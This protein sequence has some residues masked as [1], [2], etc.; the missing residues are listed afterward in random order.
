MGIV[1]KHQQD[2]A[3]FTSVKAMLPWIEETIKD[4]GGMASCG[5]VFKDLPKPGNEHYW[6]KVDY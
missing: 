2:Y 3:V 4:N 1:S 6:I 5:L